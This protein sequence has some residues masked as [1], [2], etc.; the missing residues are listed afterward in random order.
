MASIADDPNGRR[1]ILF[2][3]PDGSRKTI[4][5]GKIDRKSAE[6][7]RR[8]VEA[9][10]SA[11]IGG[12]PVPRESAAWLAGVGASLRDKLAAVG[13][14]EAPKRSALGEF[15]RS[16]ILSRPDVKPATLEV[17]QQPCRNLTEFFG[18]DKPLRTI[19]TGDC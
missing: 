7:I 14:V 17:W 8:H 18:D 10:L 4:R 13:L 9:L 16:H 1:R 19:T 5:L 6:G 12:Q 2:V 15:L 11:R 3:A